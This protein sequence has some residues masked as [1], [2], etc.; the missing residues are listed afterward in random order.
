MGT[1][2]VSF[3]HFYTGAELL[4]SSKYYYIPRPLL[5][6]LIGEAPLYMLLF[7]P[8]PKFSSSSNF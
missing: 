1:F 4:G 3:Y 7:C 5:Y 2:E 6:S 8:D